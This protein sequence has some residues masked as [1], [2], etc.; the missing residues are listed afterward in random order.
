MQVNGIPGTMRFTESVSSAG[1]P[2]HPVNPPTVSSFLFKV[3][4]AIVDVVNISVVRLG[5]ENPNSTNRPPSSC[6]IPP[7]ANKTLT[8]SSGY[9]TCLLT[10]RTVPVFAA[11][12]GSLSCGLIARI[13][14]AVM[15]AT[16]NPVNAFL[17][18]IGVLGCA[19]ISPADEHTTPQ[20]L[21][22]L[23][24]W[25]NRDCDFAQSALPSAL[26]DCSW[27]SF[28]VPVVYG[29][30]RGQGIVTRCEPRT[31]SAL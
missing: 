24:T 30:N 13:E 21:V 27:M 19:G 11:A 29:D 6:A 7:W 22:T 14:V 9:H 5:R 16:A 28:A 4:S 8:H 12:I 26:W 1:V 20:C 2:F 31:L 3:T 17:N 25:L 10:L 18:F 23:M 15:T